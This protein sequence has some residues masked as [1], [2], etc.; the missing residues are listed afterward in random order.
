MTCFVSKYPPSTGIAS[1]MTFC[2]SG[3]MNSISL[4]ILGLPRLPPTI[5]GCNFAFGAQLDQRMTVVSTRRC[6]RMNSWN[7]CSLHACEQRC[8]TVYDSYRGNS[9][10]DFCAMLCRRTEQSSSD[11]GQP[12]VQIVT[13]AHLQPCLIRRMRL[14][15]RIRHQQMSNHAIHGC[16]F[17]SGPLFQFNDEDLRRWCGQNDPSQRT[18]SI[19]FINTQG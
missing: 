1:K 5:T 12:P 3:R 16:W 15:F 11:V 19:R 18:A 8:S 7:T 4:Q 2:S 9:S 6:G 13:T 10:S 17:C 14:R